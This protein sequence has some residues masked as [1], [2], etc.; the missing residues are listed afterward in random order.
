MLSFSE[1]NAIYDDTVYGAPMEYDIDS[2]H[3]EQCIL[4]EFIMKE[5]DDELKNAKTDVS[6]RRLLIYSQQRYVLI[7]DRN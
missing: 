3:S 2:L 4:C 6:A 7:A 5:V 1:T